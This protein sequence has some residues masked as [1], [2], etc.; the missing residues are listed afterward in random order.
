[1]LDFADDA[2]GAAGGPSGKKSDKRK[3]TTRMAKEI[4]APSQALSSLESVALDGLVQRQRVDDNST[5]QM[6]LRDFDPK[7]SVQTGPGIPAWSW[8]SVNLRW[9]GPVQKDQ[10]LHLYLLSPRAGPVG[11]QLSDAV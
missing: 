6:R 2:P 8:R 5:Y 10:S 11:K 4:A 7:A 1:M 3:Q 9:S